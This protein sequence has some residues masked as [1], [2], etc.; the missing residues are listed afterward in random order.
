MPPSILIPGPWHVALQMV[1][2][3]WHMHASTFVFFFELPPH[4]QQPLRCVSLQSLRL[5]MGVCHAFVPD[6]V[7]HFLQAVT[8]CW[9]TQPI[10]VSG[11]HLSTCEPYRPVIDNPANDSP[12]TITRLSLVYGELK[13]LAKAW[14]CFRHGSLINPVPALQ[15]LLHMSLVKSA[16]NTAGCVTRFATHAPAFA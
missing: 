6:L 13:K 7:H 11:A 10:P 2:L 12:H 1:Q 14:T 4:P 9:W 16:L 5:M 15:Y 8:R 3:R